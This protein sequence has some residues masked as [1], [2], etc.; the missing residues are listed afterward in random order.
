MQLSFLS[1]QP[2]LATTQGRGNGA[3]G[4]TRAASLAAMG[5]G[6]LASC[7]TGIP[8]GIPLHSLS[9]PQFPAEGPQTA[10]ALLRQQFVGPGLAGIILVD[11]VGLAQAGR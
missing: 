8:A 10:K 7:R 5:A 9:T 6:M 3:G 2:G 11:E 4:L 1:A